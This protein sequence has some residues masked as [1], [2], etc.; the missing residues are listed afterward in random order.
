MNFL[1][2]LIGNDFD[3]L[4]SM[5]FGISYPVNYAN[6]KDALSTCVFGFVRTH[7]KEVSQQEI[8]YPFPHRSVVYAI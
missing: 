4:P 6:R 3:N 8:K 7:T 5:R 1:C 2:F